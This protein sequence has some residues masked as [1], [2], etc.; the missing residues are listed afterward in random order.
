MD[1][2]TIQVIDGIETIYEEDLKRLKYLESFESYGTV[3]SL[4]PDEESDAIFKRIEIKK[5]IIL[6]LVD[7]IKMVSSEKFQLSDEAVKTQKSTKSSLDKNDFVSDT[8]RTNE[9]LMT[10]MERLKYEER[11]LLI[12]ERKEKLRELRIAN[13]IKEREHGLEQE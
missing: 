6:I 8:K 7:M 9:S 2:F 13:T 10:P 11:M 12:E 3:D 4:T 5:T 1:S